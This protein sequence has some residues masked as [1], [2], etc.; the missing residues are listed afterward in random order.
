MFLEKTKP[1]ISLIRIL[2]LIYL[3]L[4]INHVVEVRRARRPNRADHLLCRQK[5]SGLGIRSSAVLVSFDFSI[6]FNKS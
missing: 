1:N 2:K 3:S 4:L 6:K 5:N